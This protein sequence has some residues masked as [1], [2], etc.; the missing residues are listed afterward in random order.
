MIKHN[1]HIQPTYKG[2]YYHYDDNIKRW[3]LYTNYYTGSLMMFNAN[4]Y[5]ID[6]CFDIFFKEISK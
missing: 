1:P 3:S 2:I 6:Q 4:L 5:R